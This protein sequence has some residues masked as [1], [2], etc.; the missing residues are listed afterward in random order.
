MPRL[1]IH[2]ARATRSLA[3]GLLLL[4][5]LAPP[6][7]AHAAV[8]APEMIAPGVVSTVDDEFGFA[9]APDGRRAVF[10]KRTPTTNTRPLLVVCETRR[11]AHGWGEPRVASFSGRYEDFGLG[12]SPDGR[13]FFTSNRPDDPGST[14]SPGHSIW[15]VDATTDGWGTPRR[16]GAPINVSDFDGCPSVAADGTLYFASSRPGGK[17]GLDLYR[18]RVSGDSY[19]EPE[20]LDSLNTSANENQPAIAADQSLLVF[21]CTNRHDMLASGGAAYPRPD[22]YVARSE[23][24]TFRRDEHLA[25]PVNSTGSDSYGCFS[26]D[27][28]WFYFSSDRGFATVPMARPLTAAAFERGRASLRNGCNNIYRVSSAFVRGV[29]K[30]R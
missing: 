16:L 2:P 25:E 22:L 29:A 15:V 4:G 20:A 7:S 3:T 17:G 27:G 24:G 19:A 12:F 10:V 5:P 18:A 11:G 14:A 1:T 28:S 30:A 8:G 21:T 23:A 6:P 13:L 9:V 26:A